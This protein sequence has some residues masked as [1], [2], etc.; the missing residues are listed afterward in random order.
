[1][2][3]PYKP[4]W[5]TSAKV[6]FLVARPSREIETGN[7]ADEPCLRLR[8]LFRSYLVSYCF[9]DSS[10]PCGSSRLLQAT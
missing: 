7:F 9:L 6:Q 1:M 2:P 3:P 10:T 5:E 8:S 4:K